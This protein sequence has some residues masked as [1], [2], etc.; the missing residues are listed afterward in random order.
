MTAGDPEKRLQN[1]MDKL[2]R[3][4]KPKPSLPSGK[5][6]ESGWTGSFQKGMRV[7][8]VAAASMGLL[9]PAPPCRPW[10]RGDLMRRLATFKAMT[11]FG[12]PKAISPVNCARRGWINVE[13]D[14]IACEACG[15]RLL[16]ATPSSWPLQQVEKAAAVFSLKLDNGHKLLCPWIDNACDEALTLFPPSPPHALLESYRERSLAL[17]KL[18]ALPVISSSA[19]NYMKMKSPQLENFLSE[20]SDYPINLSKGI[21][22]VDS[23]ICKD[24]DGGYGTVTADLFYQVWK[25]ICLCGWEPR[26]LPYV[27]DCEDRSDLLGENSPP[28]KSSP[29]ILHEQKDGLT[30]YSSGIGDIELRSTGVTNDDYD[31]ASV[32]LDC[33]FCGACVA[34]WA[35]ATVRRPLELYTI[36][37]DSSNQN[38]ATTSRVLVCKTEASGAVN[39]D[40]GT[41]DSSKG[42]TDTCHGGSAMKEKSLGSNLSIA[43][44]PPPRRQN[45]Q[46]RVSFPIV[47]RHLRT[48]LSSH[49][50]CVSLEYSCENQVNNECLQ[51]E[52]DPS[53][54]QNDTGGALVRSHSRGLLKRKKSENESLFRDGDANALSQLDKDI[55]GAS[56]TGGGSASMGGKDI[57]EHEANL[58]RQDSNL[59]N[60]EVDTQNTLEVT[61]GDKKDAERGEVSHEIAEGGGETTTTNALLTIKNLDDTET[62]S[63]TEKADICSKSSNETIHHGG[64]SNNHGD[65][66][67]SASDID[68]VLSI[69]CVNAE[70]GEKDCDVK[71]NI[72]NLTSKGLC[73]KNGDANDTLEKESTRMLYN[74]TSQ[75]DPI[76]RHRPYCPWVAPDDGE[77]VPGWKLTL[78]AVVHHKKD[79]SLASLETS[80]TLLDDMDDPIV[81]VRKLFSSPSPKRLKGSR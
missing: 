14:V 29:P 26:L 63:A 39:L 9:G 58:L 75:F 79:S 10:D 55:H 68:A 17:L 5:R 1:V 53:W 80:S 42:D 71:M 76:R 30:I 15:A 12:K 38:E 7:P 62:K 13:M 19:I 60:Q 35:F 41:Y 24:M 70:K 72:D 21:K 11:W 61:H 51:V 50:N 23:S 25:I 2:Y 57:I 49:R 27:V 34:L 69:N 22:I 48:E 45:F 16:F 46:P 59:Q 33:R 52:S 18:S 66:T 56:I 73:F 6:A 4:P 81:S 36:V 43:G 67:T 54:L 32:V 44:G 74:R 65:S 8:A 3:A 64:I 40:L 37:S 47:S 31:P 77:A 78:S 28:S 20:S